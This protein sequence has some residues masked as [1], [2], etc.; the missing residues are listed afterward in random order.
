MP[1]AITSNTF[2]ASAKIE[3]AIKW[4]QQAA[5]QG[6]AAAQ[7]NLGQTL[8]RGLGVA[9]DYT[10]AIMWYRF[11]PFHATEWERTER[12]REV[13]CSEDGRRKLFWDYAQPPKE[14]QTNAECTYCS[15][16]HSMTVHCEQYVRWVKRD[17][18]SKRNIEVEPQRT[19]EEEDLVKILYSLQPPGWGHYE[20]KKV[21]GFRGGRRTGSGRGST[22]KWG[23]T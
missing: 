22:S 9:Q 4:F 17:K 3:E 10:E 23:F 20:H 18:N 1:V 6:L 12:I 21:E 2:S 7:Y 11:I 13:L 14:Y 8:R 15:T 19:L 5:D 16:T